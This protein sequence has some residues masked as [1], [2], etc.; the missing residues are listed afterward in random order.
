MKIAIGLAAALLTGWLWHGPLGGGERFVG[1]L[2]RQA[3]A[4]V[5]RSELPGIA[6]RM[7]RDPLTRS[8]TIAGSANDVQ[9][10]GMGGQW[11]VS[12]HV[13]S[14]PGIAAVRWDD[15]PGGF[16]LPVLAELLALVAL[17]WALGLG[18]GALLVRRR[19][20]RSYLD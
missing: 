8:A 11:G 16:E 18:L 19:R 9:R 20:R 5:Q 13:R 6:V 1:S 7:G 3:R 15:E 14:V 4:A 12:D 2:E 10:E 17:A